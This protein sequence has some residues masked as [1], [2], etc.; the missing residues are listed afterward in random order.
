MVAGKDRISLTDRVARYEALRERARGSNVNDLTLLATDYLNHVNEIV[1]LLE[2][3]PDA[4]ECLEDC[5]AWQPLSYEDHFRNSGIA[6]KELAI[7]AYP[8][9]PPQYKKPF[10]RL[11]KEMNRLVAI[12]VD[13]LGELVEKGDEEQL[14]FVATRASQNLQD[15]IGKASAVIH[16]DRNVI[17]QAQIDELMRL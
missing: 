13:R 6:D 10:D 11:V 9:S 4:P 7:D 1:M 17:D 14:R 2:L 16:G 8:W 5:R 15:L 3:V 12:S